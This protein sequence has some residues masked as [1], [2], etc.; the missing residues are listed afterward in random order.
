[1]AVKTEKNPKGSGRRPQYAE[2]VTRRNVAFNVS[3]DEWAAFET[4]A[5]QQGHTITS[6][7]RFFVLAE[8][9]KVQEN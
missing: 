4:A 5:Q 3:D 9:R 1:M 7:I 2:K 8:G 6:Y